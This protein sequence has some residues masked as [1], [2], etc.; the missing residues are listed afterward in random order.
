MSS[1]AEKLSGYQ[2]VEMV[3]FHQEVGV[4]DILKKRVDKIASEVLDFLNREET[5]E[6]LAEAN[7]PGRSSAR[8]QDSFLNYAIDSGF[9]SEA[10]GLFENYSNS[11]LRPDYY[12]NLGEENGILLEVERGKTTINNMDLLD[13]WK[14]HLCEHANY[15]FLMVPQALRQNPKMKPRKEF[16]TVR[17]RL[18]SFFLSENYTNVRGLYIFGY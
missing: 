2:S 18:E 9:V 15:L 13:M 17:K 7:Q 4:D 14:C 10:K 5:L 8:V 1:F 6:K 3:S 11:S 12:L 16:N